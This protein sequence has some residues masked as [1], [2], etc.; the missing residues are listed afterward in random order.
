MQMLLRHCPKTCNECTL[1]VSATAATADAALTESAVSFATPRR[2][3]ISKLGR[4]ERSA[5]AST[6]TGAA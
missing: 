4:L 6:S 2:A 3:A 5:D 1:A